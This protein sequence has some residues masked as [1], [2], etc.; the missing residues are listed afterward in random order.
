MKIGAVR[1]FGNHNCKRGAVYMQET[2]EGTSEV[3]FLR[4]ARSPAVRPEQCRRR[5]QQGRKSVWGDPET[6]V[7][8]SPT[9]ASI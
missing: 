7:R 6:G 5:W 8:A 2:F 4:L 9:K 1:P 3:R